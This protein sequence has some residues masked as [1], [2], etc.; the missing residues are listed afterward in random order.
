[1]HVFICSKSFSDTKI[2]EQDMASVLKGFSVHCSE[3]STEFSVRDL[4]LD[5]SFVT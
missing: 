3:R 4:G 1:M 5:L 2:G